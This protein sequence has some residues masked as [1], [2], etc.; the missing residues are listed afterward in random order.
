MPSRVRF[1]APALPCSG[2][3]TGWVFSSV[4]TRSGSFAEQ[5]DPEQ[6]VYLVPAFTGLGAPWWHAE[7]RAALYG[8]IRIPL[9]R[10]HVPSRAVR[11]T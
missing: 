3:A 1:S 8:L 6:E 11:W 9:I 10:T 5:A 4:P 2:C 7:A